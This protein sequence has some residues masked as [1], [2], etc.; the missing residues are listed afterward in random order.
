MVGG[1]FEFYSQDVDEVTYARGRMPSRTYLSRTFHLQFGA[2]KDMPARYGFKVFDIEVGQGEEGWEWVEEVLS[3]TPAGR[4]QVKVMLA[5]EAGQIRKVQIQRVP[6]NTAAT[7]LEPGVTLDAEAVAKLMAFLRLMEVTPVHDSEGMRLDDGVLAML[8]EDPGAAQALYDRDP[9]SLRQLISTDV[10]ARD[11]AALARRRDV[12]AKMR[13]WLDQD[14]AEFDHASDEA[15]GPERAWQGLFEENPWVLGVGLGGRLLTNWDDG[16]L[17]RVV[18]GQ[19]ISEQG[20]RIDAFMKT[21]GT[22]SSVVLAEIK[23]HRTALLAGT[24]YR[25]GC[26]SPSRELTGA[27]VQVQQSA[28]RASRDLEEQLHALDADGAELPE[29]SFMLRPRSFLVVGSLDEMVGGGGGVVRDKF[30]SFE[31]FRRNLAE[32]EVLTFDEVLARAEWQVLWLEQQAEL[33]AAT[34]QTPAPATDEPW[35][36]HEPPWATEEPPF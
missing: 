2:D 33:G 30:R 3:Q 7:T 16:T 19:T 26:W 17:E 25:P 12:V 20:K 6:T 18:G 28:Y 29:G 31:L 27:V 22:V 5:R 23:H 21:Q 9:E 10:D 34:E 13:S 8:L 24:A 35:A 36:T 32:P 14:G 15:G 1:F 11:V 4:Y